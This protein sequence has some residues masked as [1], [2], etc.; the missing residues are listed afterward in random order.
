[1]KFRLLKPNDWIIIHK[2]C[3]QY[4]TAES[5]KYGAPHENWY[6]YLQYSKSRNKYKITNS[7]DF[8]YDWIENSNTYQKCLDKQISLQKQTK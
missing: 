3:G 2:E 1:M 8:N 7:L 4:S 6:C 5:R